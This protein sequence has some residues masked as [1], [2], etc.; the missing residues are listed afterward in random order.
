MMQTTAH[1]MTRTAK[2]WIEALQLLPHP[3][4]GYHREMLR[5]ADR[6]NLA[7]GRGRV[8]YTSIYFLLT[9][10][11]PSRFHRLKSDEVWYFH[12]A[13]A[14]AS[15]MVAPGFE[16]E[17]FELAGQAELLAAHPRH[18][19]LIRRLAHRGSDAPGK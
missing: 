4:G 6:I 15:C 16:F 5:S 13:F 12:T 14:L 19:A 1:A 18:H 7:D 11:N 2:D 17:N 8:C 9:H 3:E 10:E